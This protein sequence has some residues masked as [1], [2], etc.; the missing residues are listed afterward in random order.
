MS[1]TLALDMYLTAPQDYFVSS[2]AKYPAFV[3]G[4]GSGKSEALFQ[5]LILK[6]LGDLR[7]NVGYFAPT[8]DLI[9][10]IA[11]PRFEEKLDQL[12]L[13]HKL[14][15]SANTIDL[16]IGGSIILRTLENPARIVGFE[17]AHAG[18]D[19]LD[20]LDREHAKQAWQKV[21]ARCRQRTRTGINT[22]AVATTPEGFRFVYDTWERNRKPGYVL[23][24]APTRS[25]PFIPADYEASLRAT[26]PP[27]L[28]EAYLEGRFVNLLTGNVYPNF[29]RMLNHT[30]AVIA[31]R[32]PLHVGMDFNVL[33]M[34]A[35][36]SVIRDGLPLTLAEHTGVRDTP[37]M[38]RLLKERYEGHSV[39][40]YPDASGGSKHSSNASESDLTILRSAGLTVRVDASNPR[41]KDRVNSLDAM[42]LNDV[43]HRRLKVNTDRC[44]KLTEA[45]EQQAWGEDG[46]PD[47]SSGHDHPNDA[48]GYFVWSRWPLIR[49]P[50][51]TL[52]LGIAM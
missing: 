7:C 22:V 9:R 37:T 14:N 35:I 4:Y 12:K 1:R 43:G 13:R 19:E 6:K 42:T 34:T 30:D 10:L 8:Y 50:V 20:T 46:E 45:L 2:Q 16:R 52:P 33:N 11:W 41:V 36:V 27:Q 23:Y 47:K 3:G 31:S 48:L 15:K 44:P 26:Y 29:S 49:K 28:C 24:R 18:V 32:E 21:I 25:N 38:A 5:R 17:V 40:V 39:I 51:T